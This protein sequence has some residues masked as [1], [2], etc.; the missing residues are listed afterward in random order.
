M[1]DIIDKFIKSTDWTVGSFNMLPVFF[2]V[3]LAMGDITMMTSAKMVSQGTLASSIGLPISMSA[4]ALVAYFF[5]R[6]LTY[7]RMVVTN[8]VWN[9]MSNVIVTLSGV[10]FFGESIKGLRWVAIGMSL[11]A[12]GIFAYT[13]DS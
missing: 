9:M 12:M 2:G 10:I 8:L 1:K 4:Y 6:A 13:N 5:T 11:I 3:V 7:E